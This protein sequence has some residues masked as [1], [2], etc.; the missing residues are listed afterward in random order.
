MKTALA[1]GLLALLAG[2]ARAQEDP[3]DRQV[4]RLKESLQ[5]SDDQAAKVKEILKKQSEDLRSVLNDEQKRRYEESLSGGG[6][7]TRGGPGGGA[8]P[9][10]GGF[11][12]G[13]P[14][15]EE[16]KTQ[17]TLTDDQ[18]SKINALRDAAREE[19][20]NLFRNR[21]PG[22]NPF[23]DFQKLR[24]QTHA[25]I[26][27][28]L[29]DEQK[30]K[31][32]EI[33]KNVQSQQQDPG[34][35]GDR[36]GRGDRGGTLDERAARV[37]ETLRVEKPEEAEAIKGVVKKVLE[38]MDKLETYQRDSRGKIEE[39]SRNRE[40]SDEAVGDKIEELRKGQKEIEK[41]LAGARQQL[42][43]IVTNRQELEL[44]RRGVLR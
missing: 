6:R 11:R 17:L 2:A 10:A 22:A 1:A 26:R 4:Q 12:G 31:F 38:L 27:E 44:L 25:K 3:V 29:T 35:G 16:L 20:R 13:L 34:G 37:M 9:W 40:V 28:L 33:L 41:E 42:A 39:L 30:P 24:D 18:V 19:I 7:G 8:P 36:R 15:T 32:D 21:Q 43:E 23:E 5:L 14:Q